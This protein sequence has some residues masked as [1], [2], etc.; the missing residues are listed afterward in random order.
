MRGNATAR[1]RQRCKRLHPLLCF[2]RVV[3]DGRSQVSIPS[4]CKRKQALPL[5][6]LLQKFVHIERGRIADH[7][8]R[9]VIPQ[10]VAA[11]DIQGSECARRTIKIAAFGIGVH[12]LERVGSGLNLRGPAG[13]VF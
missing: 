9:K 4:H 1:L 3:A 7:I 11:H 5:V 8:V 10:A 13:S 2:S 12:R 6:L